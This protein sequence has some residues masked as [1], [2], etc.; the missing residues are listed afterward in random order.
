MDGA[1]ACLD[2]T[3]VSGSRF[4]QKTAKHGSGTVKQG[5][6]AANQC[7]LAKKAQKTLPKLM[8]G[9]VFGPHRRE[10][11]AFSGKFA[12]ARLARLKEGLGRSKKAHFRE[13]CAKLGEAETCL[14]RT[15]ASGSQFLRSYGNH[16]KSAANHITP[17]RKAYLKD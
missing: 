12:E 2:R 10:R 15:G 1:N 13:K 8:D 16:C 3:G 5:R 6:S 7:I 4:L 9:S 11:I 17:D 14:D